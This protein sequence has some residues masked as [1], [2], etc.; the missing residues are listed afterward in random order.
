MIFFMTT[1]FLD[2]QESDMS[3]LAATEGIKSYQRGKKQVISI[4]HKVYINKINEVERV[5]FKLFY[6]ILMTL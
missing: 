5:P 2:S 3:L 6:C 4:G 1:N